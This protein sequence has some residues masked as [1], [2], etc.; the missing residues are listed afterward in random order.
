[1][2]RERENTG[3]DRQNKTKQMTFCAVMTALGV[4]CLMIASM[5]PGMRIALAAIAGVIAAFTVVQ[6][7]IKYGVMTVIATAILAFLFAPGKEIALLYAV[8]FGPYTLI[9]N[10]IERLNRMWLEWV[11]KFAFCITVSGGLFLFADQVL[12]MVP[13]VLAQSILIFLPVVA[14][15]FAAYDVVFSKLIAYMFSRFHPERKM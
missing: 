11:L 4:V 7:G 5:M 6:G 1:M 13:A 2:E 12:A 14:I 15:V 8:F 10:L 9:K 3:M